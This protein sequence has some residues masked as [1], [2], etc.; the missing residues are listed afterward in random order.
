VSKVAYV[1]EQKLLFDKGYD[2][3]VESIAGYFNISLKISSVLWK[4]AHRL[5]HN[6]S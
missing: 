2:M 5:K 1:N 3:L 4:R 6:G